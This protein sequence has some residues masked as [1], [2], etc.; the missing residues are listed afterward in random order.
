[1]AGICPGFRHPFHFNVLAMSKFTFLLLLVLPLISIRPQPPLDSLRNIWNNELAPDS[2][3]ALALHKI[4][5]DGYLYSKPDSSLYYAKQLYEFSSEK[6][7]KRMMAKSLRTQGIAYRMMGE[8]A[9]AMTHYKKSYEISEEIIDLVGMASTLNSMGILYD[10]LGNYP[11]A[12]D[13]YEK[14]LKRSEQIA[15]SNGMARSYNNIGII[16]DYEGDYSKALE[17]YQKSLDIHEKAN[18]LRQVSITL[19]NIGLSYTNLGEYATAMVYYD[20]GL[21][22]CKDIMNK[23]SQASILNNIGLNYYNQGAYEKALEY[24]QKSL[25]IKEEVSDQ[26]GIAGAYLEMSRIYYEQNRYSKAAEYSE[27]GLEKAIEVRNL[28]LQVSA[29]GI[30]YRIYKALGDMVKALEYHEKSIITGDSLQARETSK[31]LQQ[32]EFSKQMLADSLLQEEEKLRVSIAH[33]AEVRRKNRARNIFILAAAFLLLGAISLYRRIVF[34]R[35]AKRTIE[36]E[37][38][39]SDNLLLNILPSEIAEEL[40][41]TGKAKARK[42]EK[43]SIL[44]TD[45]KGFTQTSEKLGAEELVDEINTCFEIF[46]KICQKYNIEKIKTIG[47][48]YMAAGGLPVPSEESV[49]N[50]V[51][52]GIEMSESM[53]K[54]KQKRKS[55]GKSFFEMRVGIHTGA[56]IAGIVGTTKFQYDIWGDSVNIASR[57]ETSGEVGKV[58]ISKETYGIIHDDPDFNFHERG[59]VSTKGKGEMEM[60][61]VEKTLS[62]HVSQEEKKH[63]LG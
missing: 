29:Y 1:M 37:K 21:K 43:V 46:D 42:F 15:D 50:T 53:N 24:Y 35:K 48:S 25:V 5:W 33:E 54:L 16:Y 44:F 18:N 32:I 56:V 12:L 52:A 45:F 14:S 27:K 19:N 60:W 3:R 11:K 13:Y 59:K 7:L 61:F 55:E 10:Y 47:D 6:G 38:E 39:K 63:T 30:L 26:N 4:S 23:W 31:K 28:N 2:A 36:F 34:V 51:L 49:K 8:Y 22:L 17:Y 57:M 62:P 20:R 9:K 40:K 41:E 58:N